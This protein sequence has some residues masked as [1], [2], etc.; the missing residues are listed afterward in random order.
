VSATARSVPLADL[1]RAPRSVSGSS[2][3]SHR[4]RWKLGVTPL[5]RAV[6]A[7][8][9]R[10]AALVVTDSGGMQGEAGML[11]TPGITVT[12][13]TERQVTLEIGANRLVGAD[14]DEILGAVADALDAPTEWAFPERWDAEGSNRAVEALRSGIIALEP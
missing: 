2:R 8:V 11:H 1:M 10:D 12:R 4:A 6:P 9:Q 14:R 3:I 7:A 13:N 5:V